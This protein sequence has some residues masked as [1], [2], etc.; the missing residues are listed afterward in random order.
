MGIGGFSEDWLPFFINFSKACFQ[1]KLKDI[2]TQQKNCDE[3]LCLIDLTSVSVDLY[4]AKFFKD[5]QKAF[6]TS[7]CKS[8]CNFLSC[9]DNV[10]CVLCSK[11]SPLFVDKIDTN[12]PKCACFFQPV[13]KLF[14]DIQNYA[15]KF[16]KKF[17][18]IFMYD[19]RSLNPLARLVTSQTRYK[20]TARLSETDFINAC[21]DVPHLAKKYDLDNGIATEYLSSSKKKDME[22][23]S[24][25]GTKNESDEEENDENSDDDEMLENPIISANVDAFIEQR[26]LYAVIELWLVQLANKIFSIVADKKNNGK[27]SIVQY[28]GDLKSLIYSG[29][30]QSNINIIFD[31][32]PRRAF[33]LLSSLQQQIPDKSKRVFSNPLFVTLFYNFY[34]NSLGF[35]KSTIFLE[36]LDRNKLL[37]GPSMMQTIASQMTSR[38][39][40]EEN[41]ILFLDP[42]LESVYYVDQCNY[43]TRNIG[44]SDIKI[45]PYI[46][47]FMSRSNSVDKYKTVLVS[48]KDC[49]IFM[50]LM[51]FI[52]D[53]MNN[54]G[55]SPFS[56]DGSKIYEWNK[57]EERL[58]KAAKTVII[59]DRGHKKI[60]ETNLKIAS[61]DVE[62][63]PAKFIADSNKE[64]GDVDPTSSSA[65][66]NADTKDVLFEYEIP[67]MQMDKAKGSKG[68]KRSASDMEK[69]KKINKS[70]AKG[71]RYID[72]LRFYTLFSNQI[73]SVHFN[74]FF[75]F[76]LLSG[77]DYSR[78][79]PG[80]ASG[81]LVKT[82]EAFS[83]TEP[84]L[85]S[86]LGDDQSLITISSLPKPR[87]ILNKPAALK[88]LILIYCKN[89]KALHKNHVKKAIS[90]ISKSF[91]TKEEFSDIY[92]ELYKHVK[93]DL[94]KES[95]K[96]AAADLKKG[97]VKKKPTTRRKLEMPTESEMIGE[98]TR[99]CWA[100][101]YYL[102]LESEYAA[103][104][105]SCDSDENNMAIWGWRILPMCGKYFSNHIMNSD[106][107]T[108]WMAEKIGYI[109]TVKQ[110]LVKE[111]NGDNTKDGNILLLSGIDE[112]L[113]G[114]DPDN[115]KDLVKRANDLRNI[116]RLILYIHKMKLEKQQPTELTWKVVKDN[117]FLVQ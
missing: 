13:E 97:T 100:L 10:N 15:S 77:C 19:S 41:A 107:V 59:L 111:N 18:M 66:I 44:E 68:I 31:A 62:N 58:K 36:Q 113:N 101:N 28:S 27:Y 75:A 67:D 5:K 89:L 16:N 57:N 80:I 88:M 63:G 33:L 74:S 20:S 94:I 30:P 25:A 103:R 60:D 23:D 115:V 43:F 1:F 2:K 7:I 47:H 22:K 29:I 4:K 102:G 86:G 42:Y 83:T 35:T 37:L 6:E 3:L 71:V 26:Y 78:N 91:Y 87:L 45:I 17:Y 65:G 61:G 54:F 24:D 117:T 99:I 64:T 110:H 49:D 11:P 81:K 96:N 39:H 93:E 12:T 55:V 40:E 108:I 52:H 98:F 50:I 34:V 92:K 85:F 90:K 84:F 112:S 21:K 95:A 46:S 32:I 104:L 69:Q 53:T 72:V 116:V 76:M 56:F 105:R 8:L 38:S 106:E 51:L 79:F 82:F 114:I 73:S 109:K 70:Y 48:T 9:F 14:V